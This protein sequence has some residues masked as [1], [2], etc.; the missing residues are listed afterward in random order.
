MGLKILKW[1]CACG[2]SFAKIIWKQHSLKASTT[3]RVR[4]PGS[5]FCRNY[6]RRKGCRSLEDELVVVIVYSFNTVYCHQFALYL[7]AS[8]MLSIYV[9]LSTRSTE[10]IILSTKLKKNV[11]N[12][13]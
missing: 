5:A 3:L 6:Q 8:V 7:V 10:M 11:I 4:S 1:K 2:S 12:F 9:K 13:M